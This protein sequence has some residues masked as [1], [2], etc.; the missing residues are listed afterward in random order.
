MWP[1]LSYHVVEDATKSPVPRLCLPSAGIMGV[2][3]SP[4]I[5]QR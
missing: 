4:W 3:F 1:E 2:L 5:I